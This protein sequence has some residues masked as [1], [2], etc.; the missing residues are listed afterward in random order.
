ML[1]PSKCFVNIFSCTETSWK[2]EFEGCGRI[3]LQEEISRLRHIQAVVHVVLD[4]SSWL[5]ELGM[6]NS[7]ERFEKLKFTFKKNHR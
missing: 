6:K 1:Q 5:R 2:A 4:V 7:A 3:D